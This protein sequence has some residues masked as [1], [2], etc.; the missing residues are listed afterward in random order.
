[1]KPYVIVALTTYA[2]LNSEQFGRDLY[3]S[4]SAVEPR[5]LPQRAGWLGTLSH[6][7]TSKEDFAALWLEDRQMY[8]SEGR[9]GKLQS[10]GI[11]MG[12]EWAR[13]SAIKSRG[14][15]EHQGITYANH[16]EALIFR[17]EWRA[18]V[19]WLDLFRRLCVLTK[20]AHGMLHLYTPG[21]IAELDPDQG[22]LYREGIHGQRAFTYTTDPYGI[23]RATGPGDPDLHTFRVLPEITWGTWLGKNFN[24][25]YDRQSLQRVV[26]NSEETSDGFL[27]TVTDQIGDVAEDFGSFRNRREII[28][29]R[30]LRKMFFSD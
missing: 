5:L 14:K 28:K 30:G 1:M 17:S 22:L 15:I 11:Y 21:E 8:S 13:R 26:R 9:R 25:Q 29:A 18:R 3:S 2:D 23:R 20:A 27:F 19:A 6:D 24:G 12:V 7:V 10:T 4:I 16:T